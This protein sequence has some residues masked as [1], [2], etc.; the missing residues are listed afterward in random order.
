MTTIDLTNKTRLT[1]KTLRNATNGLGRWTLIS[2]TDF[3]NGVY[4]PD[5]DTFIKVDPA[6]EMSL[7]EWCRGSLELISRPVPNSMSVW[8]WGA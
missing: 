6:K 8:E 4:F 1:G 7:I 3:S 5:S 2:G